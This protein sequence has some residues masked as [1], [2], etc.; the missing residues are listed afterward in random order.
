[1]VVSNV[2]L[3]LNL[4]VWE[5]NLFFVFESSS[6][7]GEDSIFFWLESLKGESSVY[8]YIWMFPKI[9]VPPNHPF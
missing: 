6:L 7:F 9:V 3:F 5:G 4:D 2:L 8:I 1:M